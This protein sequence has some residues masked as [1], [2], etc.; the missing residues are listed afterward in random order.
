MKKR[1]YLDNSAST[2]VDAR[3]LKAMMPYFA[4]KYGNASSVHFFGQEAQSAVDIARKKTAD[5]L[6]CDTSEIFFAGSAT[7]ANNLAIIGVVRKF[8]NE[9]REGKPHIV[10]SKIEHESVFQTVKYLSEI[11]ELEY[12]LLPVSKDGIVLI[13]K[14]TELLRG[15]TVLVSVIHANNEIGTIQPI[16]EISLLIRKFNKEIGKNI[17]FHTDAV[18]SAGFL[19]CDV[20]ALGVDMLTLSGHKIY[21]PKGVGTLFVKSGSN[22]EPFVLGSGQESGLRSGTENV[23]AIVGIG[24]ALDLV[25]K[26]RKNIGKI[27]ALRDKLISEILSEIPNSKITGSLEKRLPHHISIS[28]TGVKRE[29]LVIAMDLKGVAI[30]A[31]AACHSKALKA[32]YILDALGLSEKEKES[33]I[34]ITLGRKTTNE[35]IKY[36]LKILKETVKKLRQ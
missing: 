18:Q 12:S 1:I 28:F 21:G 27:T 35:D 16:K 30:S 24:V 17:L 3:V 34:R 19:N 20:E 8:I 23:P 7:E 15:N 5:F 36:T 6:N 10:I 29:E 32:S 14:L 2:P 25:K 9:K 4:K 31:G 26:E 33:N 11:G 13:D 22:I